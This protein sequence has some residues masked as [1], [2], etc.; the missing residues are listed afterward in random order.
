MDKSLLRTLNLHLHS[1]EKEELE[2]ELIALLEKWENGIK[3]R[4]PK[5]E[6]LYGILISMFAK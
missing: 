2:A 3:A 6:K 5:G 1:K 4:D